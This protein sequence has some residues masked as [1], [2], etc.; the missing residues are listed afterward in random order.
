MGLLATISHQEAWMLDMLRDAN[1]Q[2]YEVYS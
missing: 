1:G 2:S